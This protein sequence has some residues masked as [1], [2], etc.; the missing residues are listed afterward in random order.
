VRQ[1]IIA[2][3]VSAGIVAGGAGLYVMKQT[4]SH[5]G[6]VLELA[7]R[8]SLSERAVDACRRFSTDLEQKL[9]TGQQPSPDS[10]SIDDLRRAAQRQREQAARSE[11]LYQ[12]ARKQLT[13]SEH[14]LAV[15]R[16]QMADCARM[17]DDET[18]WQARIDAQTAA[19]ERLLEENQA[20]RRQIEALNRQLAALQEKYQATETQ[21]LQFQQ[22]HL[23]VLQ[24]QEANQQLLDQKLRQL[25]DV[26]PGSAPLPAGLPDFVPET[27]DALLGDSIQHTLAPQP[28]VEN[29]EMGVA[30]PSQGMAEP[31]R[32]TPA[33]TQPVVVPGSRPGIV[34]TPVDRSAAM[35]EI[36]RLQAQ[37]SRLES[38]VEQLRMH[39]EALAAQTERLAVRL[40][41]C[42]ADV[43]D[44]DQ[45]LARWQTV[46]RQLAQ[47]QAEFEKQ[48]VAGQKM[49]A[50]LR[51]SRQLA[52]SE[53]EQAGQ[54]L[55]QLDDT[56]RQ[57]R[58]ERDAAQQL[59]ETLI[60]QN[61]G[62]SR[63]IDA[64]R[65]DLQHARRPAESS[66]PRNQSVEAAYDSL[67]K[68]LEPEIDW[69]QATV[70]RNQK[71]LTLNFGGRI[72]FDFGRV[73]ITAEGRD[74]LKRVGDILNQM[75]MGRLRI[76]GH[77][78][79]R[80][81]RHTARHKYPSNWELSA[82]RAAAVVAFFQQ[83]CDIDPQLMEVVGHSFYHPVAD[84]RHEAGRALNRRVEIIVAPPDV[85]NMLQQPETAATAAHTPG[86]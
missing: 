50:E 34:H 81:I 5:R 70:S 28:A 74:I 33:P 10:E 78:D 25:T 69:R 47:E 32:A 60:A 22:T 11:Q 20:C 19:Q 80:R 35:D 23:E 75:D 41:T 18:Q 56:M 15:L 66:G 65:R 72:L 16:Q 83:Q 4:Q 85:A 39:G 48:M 55:Q 71:Q 45:A 30:V 1:V 36:A 52:E 21:Y 37:N 40:T 86:P 29:P 14:E 63:M 7:N 79:N 54:R 6:V 38:D 42:R 44:Q 57:A 9:S 2:V 76:I 17:Q 43:A 13:D 84:N 26:K 31:P 67:V 64:L 82:G 51:Q 12:D 59:A 49:I 3:V 24:I 73:D 46:S 27:D 58:A 61:Q 68:A 62:R 77:A 53:K 8:L